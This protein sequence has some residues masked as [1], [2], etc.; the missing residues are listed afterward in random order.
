MKKSHSPNGANNLQNPLILKIF[1]R[2]TALSQST[3]EGGGACFLTE[4]P[5]KAGPH[6]T[7][8]SELRTNCADSIR[9]TSSLSVQGRRDT[10]RETISCVA[11]LHPLPLLFRWQ[12]NRVVSLGLMPA[13]LIV[14][15]GYFRSARMTLARLVRPYS[16]ECTGGVTPVSH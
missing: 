16:P 2:L 4:M 15:T 7:Q 5:A 14:R 3:H 13:S 10:D 11:P 6:C 8:E 12:N 1:G 9:S